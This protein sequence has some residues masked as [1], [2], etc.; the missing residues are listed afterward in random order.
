[1]KVLLATVGSA[2]WSRQLLSQMRE[3]AARDRFGEHEAVEAADEADVILF[4][5]AH[6]HL[7]DW[8]M[9][10]LRSHPLVRAHPRKALVYDERDLPRDL[11]PGVYVAMPRRCFDPRRH[12]AYAYPRLLTDTRSVRDRPPDLLF[13]FQGRRAGPL[14]D[15]VF[16]LPPSPL[17]VVEDTSRHDFFAGHDARGLAEAKSRYL[18][19][20]GRSRFVLCPRGAGTASIRLFETLAAG[21]VP[22]VISDD[23]VPPAG[24]D[25][26][27]CSVRLPESEIDAAP[28]RLA[29]LEER[30][31]SMA[32][33]ASRTYDEWFAPEVWFHRVAELCGE[34]LAGG[35]LGPSR[36][37]TRRQT[38][39]DGA[40]QAKT[41]VLARRS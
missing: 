14:R 2:E 6:Q 17:A 24:I 19:V 23:W 12:R 13:S 33:A 7:S 29:A 20:V 35:K 37:W 32:G 5:N 27:A 21:R 10:G 1:M 28:A 4:V 16:A 15:R 41:R 26:K 40:R 30:W 18:D 31:A 11:L 3:L 8:R 25:W 36:Q 9:Q 39:R 38:W 22:V 34:L